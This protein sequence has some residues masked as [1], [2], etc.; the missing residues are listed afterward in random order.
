MKYILAVALCF[1]GCATFGSK[2]TPPCLAT[3]EKAAIDDAVS[4]ILVVLQGPV[5]T[6]AVTDGLAKVARDVG[7]DVMVCALSYVTSK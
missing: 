1:S 5:T 6:Q 4:R 3:I 2:P 7:P